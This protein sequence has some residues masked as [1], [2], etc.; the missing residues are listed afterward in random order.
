[1]KTASFGWELTN[2]SN[3]GADFYSKTLNPGT[4][5]GIELDVAFMV[6]KVPA[7]AGFAEVLCTS[8]IMPAMPVFPPG[9]QAFY[10]TPPQADFADP[11]FYV[12][13][14]T[15]GSHAYALSGGVL[16]AVIL[17]TWVATTGVASETHRNVVVMGLNIP[18]VAGNYFLLHL[19]HMGIAGD[20]EVQ[21]VLYYQ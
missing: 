5:C 6:T 12:P 10:Y 2:V 16:A 14:S 19:D 7:A 4:I 1:M 9:S 3:D 13:N 8:V 20:I 17:K 11:Q 18:I 21:G 15:I